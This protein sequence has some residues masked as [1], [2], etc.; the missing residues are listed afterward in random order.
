[1]KWLANAGP[2]VAALRVALIALAGATAEALGGPV[3]EVA[4]L[5]VKL[6]GSS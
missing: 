4:R 1:M 3:G 2:L 6:F 5:V